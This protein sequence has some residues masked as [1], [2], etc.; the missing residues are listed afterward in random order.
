MHYLRVADDQ[1]GS[2]GRAYVMAYE[3]M[4]TVDAGTNPYPNASQTTSGWGKSTTNDSTARPW[5]IFADDKRFYYFAQSGESGSDWATGFFGDII[6]YVTSDAYAS[7][8]VT[9]Y[10]SIGSQTFS[11]DYLAYMN[12][13]IT[14]GYGSDVTVGSLS[15]NASGTYGP[16][17]ATKHS[18]LFKTSNTTSTYFV[19]SSVAPLPYPSLGSLTLAPIWVQHNHASQNV[20]RGHMPGLWA[21]CHNRPLANNDTFSGTGALSGKTFEAFNVNT[22]GQLIIETSDT[23]S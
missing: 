22:N 19:G 7:Y 8:L 11:I 23:W 14:G 13:P 17:G 1:G 15:R 18:D 16:V 2:Y 21:P 10:A 20:V 5:V 6:S 3:A 12:G 4:T 9:R